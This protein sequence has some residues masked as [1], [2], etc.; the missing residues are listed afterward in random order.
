MIIYDIEEK[1]QFEKYSIEKKALLIFTLPIEKE[2]RVK[3]KYFY[4]NDFF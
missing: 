1:K 4:C 2:K 3:G